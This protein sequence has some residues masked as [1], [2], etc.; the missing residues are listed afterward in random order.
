MFRIG[1]NTFYNWKNKIL[2][3]IL[4]FKRSGNRII[5]EFCGIPSG[6]SNQELNL[7]GF[8]VF[9]LERSTN[10]RFK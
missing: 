7:H 6:F 1:R 8:P 10:S 3:K 2:M 9:C 5:E 4:K